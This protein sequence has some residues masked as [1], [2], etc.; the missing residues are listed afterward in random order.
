[1]SNT[2][3]T[4]NSSVI[5][6]QDPSSQLLLEALKINNEANRANAQAIAHL[7]VNAP[8]LPS[9]SSDPQDRGSQLMEAL[10]INAEVTRVSAQALAHLVYHGPKPSGSAPDP[11]PSLSPGPKS[12]AKPAQY[13]INERVGKITTAEWDAL[14]SER[15]AL[16][17]GVLRG[18]AGEVAIPDISWEEIGNIIQRRLVGFGFVFLR[19]DEIGIKNNWGEAIKGG[20]KKSIA[21]AVLDCNTAS[22]GYY[23]YTN[24]MLRVWNRLM[25][26]TDA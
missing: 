1:M 22:L 23:W 26:I 2:S 10:K 4:S 3:N 25:E 6:S 15:I 11:Q 21:A 19:R 5:S 24:E 16:L 8:H 13:V 14:G 7:A 12:T 17:V 18:I 9:S 20:D